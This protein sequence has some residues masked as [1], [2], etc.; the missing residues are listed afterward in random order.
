MILSRRLAFNGNVPQSSTSSGDGPQLQVEVVYSATVDPSSVDTVTFNITSALTNG[1]QI[2]YDTSTN[3]SDGDFSDG[4]ATGFITLEPDGS[5]TIV[6]TISLFGDVDVSDFDIRLRA[7][8]ATAQIFY[9]ETVPLSTV[10]FLDMEYVWVDQNQTEQI[11]PA[12][13]VAGDLVFNISLDNAP[14]GDENFLTGNIRLVSKDDVL[15]NDAF[16]SSNV[17]GGWSLLVGDGGYGSR[18]GS[19]G[20]I[21]DTWEGGFGGATGGYVISDEPSVSVTQGYPD[22]DVYKLAR[23]QKLFAEL[24]NVEANVSVT[25]P[26]SDYGSY[27]VQFVRDQFGSI[28]IKSAAQGGNANWYHL[29]VN[30]PTFYFIGGEDVAGFRAPLQFFESELYGKGAGAVGIPDLTGTQTEITDWVTVPYDEQIHQY[31]Y[32]PTL[33]RT[34]DD[35]LGE[36]RVNGVFE[37]YQG[38][39]SFM[40]DLNLPITPFT[41]QSSYYPYITVASGGGGA[42]AGNRRSESN[43]ASPDYDPLGIGRGGDATEFKGGNAGA[44]RRSA[45]TGTVL[46]Y[47]G[48][49]GGGYVRYPDA[50]YSLNSDKNGDCS[51]GRSGGGYDSLTGQHNPAKRG[52]G[53]MPLEFGSV[54]NCC[55]VLRIPAVSRKIVI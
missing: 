39:E 3:V 9:T 48:G 49:A 54:P 27:D 26:T 1:Q 40:T 38:G 17:A 31:F 51:P 6:R 47:A 12:E 2:H 7:G 46:E 13:Q 44:G 19:T 5:G 55:F 50:Q 18:V 34:D 36:I 53:R 25:A 8:D 30:D 10:Q 22:Q 24:V 42:G 37:P 52:G 14:G 32:T 15:F 21:Q 4:S 29:N 28:T 41:D 23:N 43:P 45:I 11:Y 35:P 20:A 16:G 33:P